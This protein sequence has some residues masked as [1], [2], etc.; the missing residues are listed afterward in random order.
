MGWEWAGVSINAWGD[1]MM[2]SKWRGT[3]GFT[4]LEVLIALV[5]LAVGMLGIAQMLLIA[6]KSNGSNYIRQNAVQSAYDILEHIRANRQA[7]INGSYNVSNLVDNGAPTIPNA[8]SID[9]A[10]ASCTA[11]Q[12]ASYDTWYWMASDLPRLPNGCGSVSTSASGINTLVAVTVQWDDS[13]AQKALGNQTPT[14][15]KLILESQL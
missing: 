7:A 6:H 1:F 5:I 4:L 10:V 8:P 13:P 14:P 3:R 15:I 2:R 12:L 9:C 11:A